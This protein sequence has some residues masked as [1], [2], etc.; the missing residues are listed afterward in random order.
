[1][2]PKAIKLNYRSAQRFSRDYALLKSGRIFLPSKTLL[3]IKTALTLNFTVPGIDNVFTIEGV[4]E[5]TVD[6]Q[7]AALLKKPTGMV[8]AVVGEPDAI[9]NKLNAV[10]CTHINYQILLGLMPP[11]EPAPP[12]SNQETTEEKLAMDRTQAPTESDTPAVDTHPVSHQ[13]DSELNDLDEAALEDDGEAN[14][15]LDWLRKAVAQEEV[16]KEDVPTAELTVAPTAEKKDLTLEERKK[17]KP[18]GEFLMD[19]TKAMLRSGYYSADHPGSEGAKQ[20]LYEKFQNC[21]DE[22][23]QVEITKQETREKVDPE[24]WRNRLMSARWSVWVWR[25]YSFPN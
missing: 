2:E 12:S 13:A 3:P 21:L 17:V 15:S 4:V 10:L 7:A 18:S 1:M 9:L 22:S 8:L 5:K 11:A 6:E 14:L 24:F 19:L 25:N 16:V 23:R 20:G